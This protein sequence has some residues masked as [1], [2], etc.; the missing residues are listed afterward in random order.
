MHPYLLHDAPKDD[1]DYLSLPGKLTRRQKIFT[2]VGCVVRS[3]ICSLTNVAM[4][5]NIEQLAS[6]VGT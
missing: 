1:E 2:S 6:N 3:G 5:A 4:A